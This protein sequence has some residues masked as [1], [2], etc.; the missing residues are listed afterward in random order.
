MRLAGV[1]AFA[2]LALGAC[3]S[4]APA[5]DLG[6]P[7][8]SDDFMKGGQYREPWL[9]AAL[10]EAASHPLGS[11]KNPVRADMPG[12]ERM[13]LARLRCADGKAPAFARTGNLGA[14]AFG[15]IVDD[16][17]VRCAGSSPAEIHVVMDMYFT[18]YQETRP[19]PG[20]TIA[21]P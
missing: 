7:Q 18:G 5:G 20:F 16:Y 1:A 17:I 15:S 9:S 8:M 10:K 4:A 13:Y 2:A 21:P 12:G 19:V 11:E 6:P 14:G 3:Q